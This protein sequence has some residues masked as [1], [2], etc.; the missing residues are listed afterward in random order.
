MSSCGD[1]AS[2]AKQGQ[3]VPQGYYNIADMLDMVA[4]RQ[5]RCVRVLHGRSRHRR[6]RA[7]RRHAPGTMA[8]LAEWHQW[9]DK[10]LVF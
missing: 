5:D 7:G 3:K 1:A 4:R 6:G 9:A 10:A 2:C 8:E